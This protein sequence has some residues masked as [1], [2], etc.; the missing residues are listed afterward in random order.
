MNTAR[1]L[2]DMSGHASLYVPIALPSVLPDY[3]GV[4]RTA[5]WHVS[6]LLSAAIETTTL[7]SRLR[8]DDGLRLHRLNDSELAL[9]VNGNQRI[10][11]LQ[12]N[13]VSSEAVSHLPEIAPAKPSERDDRV[14]QKRSTQIVPPGEDK[15]EQ[16]VRDLD[17]D[18][19]PSGPPSQPRFNNLALKPAHTFGQL[20]TSRVA[21]NTT[22]RQTSEEDDDIDE[23]ETV[24]RKRRRIAGLPV[25]IASKIPLDHPILPTFPPIFSFLAEDAITRVPAKS[26]AVRT[27]LS[28]TTAVATRIKELSDVVGRTVGMVEDREGLVNGLKE[29]A[30]QYRAGWE[31][32]GESD[33]E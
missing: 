5:P 7:S 23:D 22:P 19:F 9:N 11:R 24:A 27:S 17:L 3:V 1:S 15:E 4:W 14:P 8:K 29:L 30:E 16:Q 21:M 25:Q 26:V 10:A 6:A 33:D 13:V 2:H 20:E 18:F 28:T 32:D 12:A 31:D